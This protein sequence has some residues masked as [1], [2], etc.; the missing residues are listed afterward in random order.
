MDAHAQ[1]EIRI[2]TTEWVY[3]IESFHCVAPSE[4]CSFAAAIE[5]GQSSFGAT[6]TACFEDG[7]PACLQTTDPGYNAATG[8]WHLKS[9]DPFDSYIID[10][11]DMVMDFRLHVDGWDSPAD[12]KIVLDVQTTIPPNQLFLISGSGNQMAGMDIIGD[13]EISYLLVR[14]D[15]GGAVST[16]NVF[17][18]GLVLT[19]YESGVAIRLRGAGVLNNRIVGNW[20]GIR[21]DGTEVA[22]NSEHCVEILE[23]ASGNV[24]GGP[25]PADRNVFAGNL[26]SAIQISDASTRDNVIEGNYIG[27]DATGITAAGNST[28]I[29]LV[30]EA[31]ATKVFG[32]IISGN[33]ID[34]ILADNTST[35]FGRLITRIEDNYIGPDA[36]G[37]RGPGNAGCGIVVRGL[38]KNVQAKNNRIWFNKG[39]GVVISGANARDNTITRNS[40]TQND[41]K[42]LLVASG[43]NENVRPPEIAV[44]KPDRINGT[45]CPFCLIEVFTDPVDEA[46]SFEGETTADA[47]GAW[48]LSRPGGFAYRFVTATATDGRNTSALSEAM[49]V[50]RGDLPTRTPTGRPGATPTRTPEVRWLAVH[51][52]WAGKDASP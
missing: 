33:T 12:N 25:D 43:A 1:T 31:Q 39:C 45:A 10:R 15:T 8:K 19:G 46:E 51:L 5:R 4:P 41:G 36:S 21:G 37:V 13:V 34:G 49:L 23:G 27:L 20:C 35:E 44:A 40:M 29:A 3:P 11:D 7:N 17:G 14:A 26:D 2:N 9:G 42:A 32:N 16:E 24:I 6:V 28:G 30:R 50:E 22:A 47:T 18:P 52:P 38:A 48:V